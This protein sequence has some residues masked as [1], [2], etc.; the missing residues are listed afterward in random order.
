MIYRRN[1]LAMYYVQ[2]ITCVH[3]LEIF[4]EIVFRKKSYNCRSVGFV[5][6]IPVELF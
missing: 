2:V 3:R 5:N 6:Q 1:L 4:R